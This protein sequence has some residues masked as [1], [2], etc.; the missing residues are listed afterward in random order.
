MGLPS[1][2]FGDQHVL[3]AWVLCLIE[4]VI[5]P[6]WGLVCTLISLGGWAVGMCSVLEVRCGIH[7]ATD[8]YWIHFIHL[9]TD[10]Y[11]CHLFTTDSYCIPATIQFQPSRI[12][13]TTVRIGCIPLTDSY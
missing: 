6:T 3:F 13:S 7:A 4:V 8:L 11:Q 2:P 12:G 5:R 9:T 1:H 10:L